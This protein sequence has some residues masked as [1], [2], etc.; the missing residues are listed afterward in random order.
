MREHIEQLDASHENMKSY[1]CYEKPSAQDACHKTGFID[2]PWLQ[3]VTSKDSDF[4]F[5]GPVPFMRAANQALKDWNV[6]AERIHF[7]FFGP[8]DTL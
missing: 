5:C 8:A 6:P 1:V 2:L 7:E 3:E 4:Y